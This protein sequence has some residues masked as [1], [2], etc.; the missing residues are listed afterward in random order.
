MIVD[1]MVGH[2]MLSLMDDFLGYNQIMI[3]KDDQH[4]TTFTYPWGTYFWNM[5]PFGLKNF[6]ATYQRAMTLIFH[7]MIHKF[8]E[9][10]V[11]DILAK[12]GKCQDHISMLDLIFDRLEEYKV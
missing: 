5:M 10:Y 3:T 6:R 1:P 9:D 2:E 11:D 7:D 12:L 4:K 8:V